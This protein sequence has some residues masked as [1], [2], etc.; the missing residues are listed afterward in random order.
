[1]IE[2]KLRIV[3]MMFTHPASEAPEGH[4][5]ALADVTV[6]GNHGNLDYSKVHI[7][8]HF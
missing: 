7:E 3:L 1:M 6:A 4:S 8:S 5:G 2:I